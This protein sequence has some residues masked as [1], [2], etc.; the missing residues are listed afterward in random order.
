MQVNVY[1]QE[2]KIVDKITLSDAF[3]IEIKP[4]LIHQVVVAKMA[5]LR[6][7]I[8]HT[9]T[10]GEVSGGG[11]KPWQQK[12]TGRARAG[13]IRSPLW[14]GGG[15]IF[16]PRKTRNFFQKVNKKV[17]R[18]ALIMVLKDKIENNQLVVLDKI[19]LSEPKTKEFVN[20]LKKLPSKN[21]KTIFIIEKNLNLK[22]ATKNIPYLK[23]TK[24]SNLNLIDLLEYPYLMAEIEDW[25]KLE[26]FYS[27]RI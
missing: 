26:S 10:R 4:E 6:R 16:G 1:S 5:N 3:D 2:G 25:K 11:K 14:R 7:P 13:S 24:P 15:I 12:G 20:I 18:L 22:R 19:A 21:S 9:K 17:N 8:A 27:K 23:L